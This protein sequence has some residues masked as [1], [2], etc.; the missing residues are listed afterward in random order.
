MYTS[1]SVTRAVRFTARAP[2]AGV[3]LGKLRHFTWSVVAGTENDPLSRLAGLTQ[4]LSKDA[5]GSSPPETNLPA[6][7]PAFLPRVQPAEE[8]FDRESE[9]QQTGRKILTL[10]KTTKRRP[11]WNS[12][13]L[14]LLISLA[15]KCRQTANGSVVWADVHQHF[16]HR[17]LC[18]VK[19]KY[20][21]IK[22]QDLAKALVVH[23]AKHRRV[24]ELELLKLQEVV[25]KFGEH[26]WKKVSQEMSKIMGFSRG[27]CVYVGVWNKTASPKAQ[28]APPWTEKES[29]RLRLLVSEHGP[30]YVFLS[31]K[32]FPDYAP[33]T[34]KNQINILKA[35]AKRDSSSSK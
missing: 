14:R 33:H 5:Q 2:T 32:F 26:S 11:H 7:L 23:R 10:P 24:S 20:D 15:Q 16:K 28:S 30:D 22:K 12:E 13:E 34:I 21:L 17:T 9:Y 19:G 25:R 18:A 4:L 1:F 31:L 8:S 6:A 35:K 27:P 29:V 3:W